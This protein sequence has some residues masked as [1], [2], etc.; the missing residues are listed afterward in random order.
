VLPFEHNCIGAGK[1]NSKMASKRW[2][3]ERVI[4]WLKKKSNLGTSELQDK[5]FETYEVEVGYNT[6]WKGKQLALDSIF[7]SWEESFQSLFRFRA[8]LLE[9][10]PDTIFEIAMKNDPDSDGIMFDKL[11]LAMKPCIDGFLQGCRPYLGIDATHLNGRYKGQ[12]ATATAIDGNNW[13]YPVAWALFESETTDNWTWFMRQLEKAIGHPPFLTFATDAC[14]GL[15]AAITEVFP[16]I[17]HR[18]C[19]RHLWSN[20]KKYFRGEVYDKRMWRAA[21]AY[22]SHKFEYHWNKIV[23]A[24]PTVVTYMNLHHNNKWSRSMFSN[25]VKCDYI[26]NNLSESFNSWIKKKKDLPPVELLNSLRLMTMDLWEKRRRIG[27]KL[28]GTILPTVI[29]Q[30]NAKTRGLG[31]M[32]VQKN[33]NTAEVFGV[34]EDMTPWVQLVDLNTHTCTCGE[35]DMTGKPC[36][37]ALAFIQICPGAEMAS[38]VHEYYSVE[39][40]RTAY[41]ASIPHVIDKSMWPELDMGFKLLPPPLRRAPGRQRKNRFK[42]SHEPGARKQQRCNKCGE[43]GHR[44]TDNCPMKEPKKGMFHSYLFSF[45]T[46]VHNLQMPKTITTCK[47]VGKERHTQSRGQKCLKQPPLICPQDLSLEELPI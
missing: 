25:E 8:A 40:F 30:L 1:V 7:G 41:S 31:H 33:H 14:K 44:E 3:A 6:V 11:F 35:W 32:K 45:V 4:G 2:V 38:F 10:S 24:D 27:S 42:A 20:F 26:N 19:M 15:D 12:L 18:E 9:S 21:R 13:M 22:K 28:Q 5:L 39:R 36:P 47:C 29:K 23:E 43:Y 17:E 16:N 34:Y 46:F 37:H